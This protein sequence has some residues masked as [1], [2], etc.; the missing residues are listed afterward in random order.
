MVRVILARCLTAVPVLLAVTL[1]S[2]LL[3]HWAP[4]T[5]LDSLRF[6]PGIAPSV[7]DE[8][9]A[10]YGLDQP[11]YVQYFSWLSGL[12]VGDLGLSGSFQRPVA[13]VLGEAVPYTLALVATT[14][15]VASVAGV[16]L[17]LLATSRL[18]GQLDRLASIGALGLVS[19]HP[20]VIAIF[21][22]AVAA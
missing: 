15:L 12:V 17:G 22:L 14:F 2:F 9:S 13:D 1:L 3:L 8:L 7:L 18:P 4:G 6:Q 20:I 5:F 19:L 10:Y 16:L 11:W 21:G